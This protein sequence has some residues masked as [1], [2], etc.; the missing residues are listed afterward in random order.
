MPSVDFSGQFWNWIEKDYRNQSSDM[1]IDSE[2]SWSWYFIR[3]KQSTKVYYTSLMLF[4]RK[5]LADILNLLYDHEKL[6][7]NTIDKLI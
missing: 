3:K 1:I 4:N 2:D 5:E 7:L 6:R